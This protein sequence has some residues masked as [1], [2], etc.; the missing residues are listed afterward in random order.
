MR[1]AVFFLYMCLLLVKGDDR[2]GTLPYNNGNSYSFTTASSEEQPENVTASIQECSVV[3][4]TRP[5]KEDTDMISEDVEDDDIKS[6][7]ARK[8]KL[9][10]RCLPENPAAILTFLQG[11]LKTITF[12]SGTVSSKYLLHGVLRL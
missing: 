3:R 9:L 12:I 1:L 11:N 2:P 5:P 8:Y 4:D 7:F 6:C 10:I